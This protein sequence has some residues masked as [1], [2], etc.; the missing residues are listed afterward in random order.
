MPIDFSDFTI[1]NDQGSRRGGE[2]WV[3][4]IN[5]V[6]MES[7]FSSRTVTEQSVCQSFISDMNMV[8]SFNI[9]GSLQSSPTNIGNINN[10]VDED[11]INIEKAQGVLRV[12]R[13]SYSQEPQQEVDVSFQNIILL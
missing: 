7:N 3:E 9:P 1:K 5:S 8:T 4:N 2:F 6:P 13:F 11:S 12:K 10:A